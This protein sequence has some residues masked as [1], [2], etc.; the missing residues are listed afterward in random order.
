MMP[1]TK[2]EVKKCQRTRDLFLGEPRYKRTC[3]YTESKLLQKP[4]CH[5]IIQ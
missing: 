1:A 2:R 5:N 3:I 4:K